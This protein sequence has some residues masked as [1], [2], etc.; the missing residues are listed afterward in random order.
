MEQPIYSRWSIYGEASC[1]I[2]TNRN[3]KLS[4]SQIL[5][6]DADN[7]LKTS[8]FFRCYS[9]FFFAIPTQL[10]GVFIII[11]A[12]VEDFFNVNI[13]FKCKLNINISINDHSLYLCSMLLKAL[14]LLAHLFCNFGLIWLIEFQ[15]KTNIKIVGFQ[16]MHFGYTLDSWNIDLLDID[17]RGTDLGLLV[18]N[19]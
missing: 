6:K 19:D 5:S 11:L 13:F 18:G 4:L 9:N 7:F 1:L 15:I 17:L 12:N 14:F 10:S 3:W 8:F 16:L 2:C